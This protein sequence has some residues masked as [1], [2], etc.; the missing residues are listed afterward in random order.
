MSWRFHG[1]ARVSL[2]R[3]EAMGVCDRCGGLYSLADLQYQCEWAGP[4]L[5]NKRIRVCRTCM[6]VPSNAFRTIRIPP[7]PVPV[8]DPR[9]ENYDVAMTDYRVTEAD[10]VRATETG[11]VRIVQD[12]GDD[13]LEIL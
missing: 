2:S 9:P 6:D 5:V 13:Y 8:R 4:K 11:D 7:D 12:A 10:V 1:R 3:P